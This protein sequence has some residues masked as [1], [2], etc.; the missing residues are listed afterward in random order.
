MD[1]VRKE[2]LRLFVAVAIGA[3]HHWQRVLATATVP[4]LGL[5]HPPH[6]SSTSPIHDASSR[7]VAPLS[8][9]PPEPTPTPLLPSSA[10][11]S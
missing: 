9:S 5:G 8:S 3:H 11:A 10:T 4:W 7:D 2:S 1:G 6:E